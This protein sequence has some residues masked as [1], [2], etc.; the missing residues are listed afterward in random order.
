MTPIV[1]IILII[2]RLY[3][4]HSANTNSIIFLA[5]PLESNLYYREF[6]PQLY[7][8]YADFI[9]KVNLNNPNKN[10]YIL[11]LVDEYGRQMLL[12]RGIHE[13]N[14]FVN[15]L[16]D[17][18]I[19]I[20]IRDFGTVQVDDTLYKFIYRPDYL[21]LDDAKATDDAFRFW[22]DKNEVEYTNLSIILDGGN[23][24]FEKKSKKVIITERI[25]TDNPSF[26]ETTIIQYLK[27]TLN[28]NQ[29]AIIPQERFEATGHSDGMVTFIDENVIGINNY[30][31]YRSSEAIYYK[32]VDDLN[33]AFGK[34]NIEI[35]DLPYDPTF[36]RYEQFWSAK[37][38][39][40]N[41]LS[42][43]YSLYSP[44]Y[45]EKNGDDQLNIDLLNEYSESNINVQGVNTTEVAILG[46]AVN[47][48]SMYIWGK[49]ADNFILQHNITRN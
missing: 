36:E 6:K 42:S 20:W 1:W 4:V 43:L 32:I 40:T 31:K 38:I 26:N 15:S 49:P 12:D 34:D 29:V 25:L 10:E 30:T 14:I 16:D 22:L 46:G 8:F 44:L 19:D 27:T 35:I 11:A 5:P 41:V 2:S 47:C 45:T 48:L 39:Y 9:N 21:E 13:S 33:T 7:D 28:L 37:G 18:V 24:V 3:F 17:A 23:F